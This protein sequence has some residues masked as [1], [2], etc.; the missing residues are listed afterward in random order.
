M[1]SSA[2]IFFLLNIK[3]FAQKGDRP[4]IKKSLKN[5]RKIKAVDAYA[6]LGEGWRG[7]K[8]S[9]DTVSLCPGPPSPRSLLW[10]P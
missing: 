7:V 1:L 2:F 3:P 8:V 4:L 10:F 6:M 5:N 9:Q